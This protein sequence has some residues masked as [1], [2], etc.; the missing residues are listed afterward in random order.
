[1]NMV[2]VLGALVMIG[3][4]VCWCDVMDAWNV[5]LRPILA[6]LPPLSK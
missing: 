6:I 5:V 4:F 3:T 1:M 2:E